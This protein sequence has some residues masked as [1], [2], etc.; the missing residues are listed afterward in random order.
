M[1]IINSIVVKYNNL[2]LW[3]KILL[4]ISILATA[5][6]LLGTGCINVKAESYTNPNVIISD[7]ITGSNYNGTINESG[8]YKSNWLSQSFLNSFYNFGSSSYG[9]MTVRDYYSFITDSDHLLKTNAYNSTNLTANLISNFE[10]RTDQTGYYRGFGWY[11]AQAGQ[12]NVYPLEKGHKYSLL[13]EFY[14]QN[15]E[16]TSSSFTNDSYTITANYIISS[17]T[18]NYYDLTQI[19]SIDI[20]TYVPGMT[21]TNPNYGYVLIDIYMDPNLY[22]VIGSSYHINLDSIYVRLRNS[23]YSIDDEVDL[24]TYNYL[25]KSSNGGNYRFTNIYLLDN[26]DVFVGDE[27]YTSTMGGTYL[28]QTQYLTCDTLDLNCHVQNILIGIKSFTSNIIYNLKQFFNYVFIPDMTEIQDQINTMKLTFNT[29]FPI[30]SDLMDYFQ[31]A[32]D[33]FNSL[34]PQHEIS[35]SGVKVPGYTQTWLI[36]PFTFDFDD[37]IENQGIAPW[38]S[39]VRTMILCMLFIGWLYLSFHIISSII[40]NT[41]AT[42]D[43]ERG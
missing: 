35:F 4:A 12:S 11:Y 1:K 27:S 25:F 41:R 38:Y 39:F 29:K 14:T 23:S 19:A 31:Y 21:Y 40:Y 30:V 9:G 5:K 7:D 22:P 28:N 34:E 18:H 24:S 37:I 33:R 3:Q 16:W 32:V 2:K 36:E 10:N 6:I 8:R 17:N 42:I 26:V 15:C 13:F 20:N 43:L